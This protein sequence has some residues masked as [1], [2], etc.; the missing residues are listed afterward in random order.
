[1]SLY[2]IL[3]LQVTSAKWMNNTV[4][5]AI[6][7]TPL[8]AYTLYSDL[9]QQSTW[10]PWLTS[11]QVLDTKTGFSKW[12]ISKLGLSY[13]WSAQFADCKAGHSEVDRHV[14][15]WESLDGLPNRGRVDFYIDSNNKSIMVLNVA[16]D[17]PSIAAFL[18]EG[19]GTIGERFIENTLLSDL[20]RFNE[21]LKK[22]C[23]AI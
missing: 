9:T 1:M 11:V 7:A 3:S 19:L 14:M 12:T 22:V 13:S 15:C 4:I 10:S 23:L 6:D 2:L 5:L 16:Y 8:I 21:R 18:L 17:I 20:H